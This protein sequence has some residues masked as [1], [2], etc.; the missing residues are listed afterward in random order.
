MSRATNKASL[1]WWVIK[2]DKGKCGHSPEGDRRPA[3]LGHGEGHGAC[4]FCLSS[5]TSAST[6]ASKSEKEKAWTGRTKN[7]LLEEMLSRRTWT[8]F[9]VGPVQTS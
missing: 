9:R 4:F 7:Y 6:T 2:E 3:S 8:G 5:P 1:G